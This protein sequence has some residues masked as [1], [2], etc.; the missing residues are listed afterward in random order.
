MG[1]QGIV[2]TKTLIR[3]RV[4]YPGIDKQ[5]E[6]KVQKCRDCQAYVDQKSFEPMYPFDMP[7]GPWQKVSGDF[8]GLMNIRRITVIRSSPHG[9]QSLPTTGGSDIGK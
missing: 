4:W 3:S 6:D 2:K 7:T 8:F 1:H 9:L 5:V